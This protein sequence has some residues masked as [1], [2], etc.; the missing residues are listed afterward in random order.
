M[1]SRFLSSSIAFIFP[2]K[3]P[4]ESAFG[5][6]VEQQ[7]RTELEQAAEQGM[8]STRSQDNTPVAGNSQP[9]K[10]PHPQVVVLEKK[11]KLGNGGDDSPTQTVT[12][13]RRGSAKSNGHA[14]PSSG[15]GKRGRPRK[16][17]SEETTI[18]DAVHAVDHSQSD[19][20]PSTQSSRADPPQT[21]ENTT[22]QT[23]DY[24]ESEKTVEVA[25]S[26]PIHTLRP[27]DEASEAHK[28]V[29][30]SSGSATR[31]RKVKIPTKSEDSDG[32]VVVNTNGADTSTI[33]EKPEASS[34]T[35][36][37]ATHKRFGSEDIELAAMA[38]S[39]DTEERLGSQEDL[40]E[41]EDESEDEA[42][43]TV[44]ASAGFDKARTSALD[45]AK[46]AARYVS[47][48][49]RLCIRRKLTGN[50]SEADKRLRRR[51]HDQKL[52][53]QAKSA[54]TSR[55]TDKPSGKVRLKKGSLREVITEDDPTSVE[56][57][58]SLD[59]I[60]HIVDGEAQ[61][62]QT[63]PRSTGKTPLPL[64]LPM[65]ILAAEPVVHA[66]I[67][68]LSKNGLAI[69]QKRKFLDPE[70]KPPKDV[71]R[72]NVNIRVLPDNRSILPP[73]CSQA[74]KALRESWLTGRFGL[75]GGIQVP[76]RKPSGS[77]IRKK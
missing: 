18:G 65:E 75:K 13:R 7:I 51:E 68:P 23:I 4:S 54:K 15:A 39:D 40:P 56:K 69:S 48:R 47:S 63:K 29:R 25:I 12:K 74:S 44:T 24:E 64:L 16:R 61:T 14:A 73:Q 3:G 6:Q 72:G 36:A 30:S 9:S 60:P 2:H 55:S 77:F 38:P 66:P 31:S 41:N 10:L 43:E 37:K 33:G 53:S 76:R 46:V 42:P 17:L 26:R 58:D 11:R 35:A 71:K 59:L 62:P 57:P 20:E 32:I 21:P 70:P 27:G 22:E 50:R 34:V 67:P 19:E 5:L 45:A 28:Q 49:R 8:V 1:F 52:R